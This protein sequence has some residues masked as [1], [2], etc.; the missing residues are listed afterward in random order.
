[1]KYRRFDGQQVSPEWDRL[2]TD[3]RATGIRFHVNSGHRTLAEQ[4]R[5]FDQNMHLFGGVWVPRP[6]RP[7]TAVPNVNAPHVRPG[8]FDHAVD[9]DGAAA[10]QAGARRRGITLRAT[11]RGEPWH[12]EADASELRAYR[13]RRA[14]E[15]AA[16]KRRRRL[17]ALRKRRR[18]LLRRLGRMHTSPAGVQMIRVF[19]G[20]RLRPYNDPAGHATIGIGH[21]LHRGPVTDTDRQKWR[22]FT[23]RDA[24]DLLA[25]DLAPFEKAVRKAF[26]AAR[27]RKPSQAQFDALT[28]AAFNLGPGVLDKGRSLGD[29]VRAKSRA[30]VVAAL[31]VYTHDDHGKV[32]PGLLS[33]R[34]READA[35]RR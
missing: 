31:L 33:R 7:L 14:K 26:R 18:E 15:I 10:V 24:E 30:A 4:K 13:V 11:V 2:L 27:W 12:L 28:S 32:L 19:E 22:E 35:F 20:V 23:A 3:L 1:M 5:M 9:L 17:A 29:A 16:A 21:L 25:H 34:D 8:R 6:G